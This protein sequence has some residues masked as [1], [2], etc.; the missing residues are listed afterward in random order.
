[1]VAVRQYRDA[2]P[3]GCD[4]LW[5][6]IRE[7]LGQGTFGIT[8]LAEDLS[9]GRSVAIKEYLPPQVARRGEEQALQPLSEVLFDDY[10]SG[11]GRFI[12]EAENLYRFD[13]PHIVRVVDLFEANNTAYLVMAYEDGENLQSILSRRATLSE[14]EILRI[15][16]PL[17]EALQAL[18]DQQFAHRDVKPS[19]IF[20]RHNG[21]PVLLDFGSA[22]QI[23]PSE[24][25]TLTNLVSP[26]YAPIEQYSSS[27]EK[28]GP[29]TDIYALG[30]TLYRAVTGVI[31]A[32]A[33]ARAEALVHGGTDPHVPASE[34]ASGLYSAGLL[35]AI[36]WALQ[37]RS[38]DRPQSIED[39]QSAFDT[40]SGAGPND[41]AQVMVHKP[42]AV[43]D[44]PP[45]EPRQPSTAPALQALA[46]SRRVFPPR[47]ATRPA[48]DGNDRA[49]VAAAGR[50]GQWARAAALVG[51]AAGLGWLTGLGWIPGGAARDPA[52]PAPIGAAV[53]LEETTPLPPPQAGGSHLGWSDTFEIYGLEDRGEPRSGPEPQPDLADAPADPQD[54]VQMLLAGAETDLRANRL[55]TPQGRNAYDKYRQVL[56]L[57]PESRMAAQGIQ[58]ILDR[59]LDLVYREI[60]ANHLESAQ[61][62]LSR[63]TSIAPDAHRVTLA[64]RAL[65]AKRYRRAR[66]ETTFNAPAYRRPAA[67]EENPSG[68]A[69]SGVPFFALAAPR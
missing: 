46:L 52:P 35:E 10:A 54:A 59:Y 69:R 23:A 21:S 38:Q 8:Y 16:F 67:S 34:A 51:L 58:A 27:P 13:H 7:V 44:E 40:S 14:H 45:T 50:P 6:R 47:R 19:N 15:L 33:T 61:R 65:F 17:L 66:E 43:A 11:L 12:A 41:D 22:R 49:L 24:A 30:A 29:W 53:P 48:P 39:W 55:T 36:D 57:Q 37:F 4:L 5:Y 18:H 2:L 28:Q 25:H 60:E 26:G 31:P 3:E 68:A 56:A 32:Q 42:L 63:A 1:M 64:R 9:D 62:L 20:I